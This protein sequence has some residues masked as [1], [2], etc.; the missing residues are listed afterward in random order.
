MLGEATANLS[1]IFYD[2]RGAFPTVSFCYFAPTSEEDELSASLIVQELEKLLDI[3]KIKRELLVEPNPLANH[4]QAQFA[5]LR[6]EGT[7]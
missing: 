2:F 5:F 7:E 6:L 4:P 3:E 1:A